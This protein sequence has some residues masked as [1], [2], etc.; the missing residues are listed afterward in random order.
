MGIGISAAIVTLHA[1]GKAISSLAPFID[2]VVVDY[3]ITPYVTEA[4]LPLAYSQASI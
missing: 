2:A 4:L 1:A 3:G